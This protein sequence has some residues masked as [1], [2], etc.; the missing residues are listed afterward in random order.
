MRIGVIGSGNIGST[1]ARLFVVAGHEV[2]MANSRGPQTIGDLV[3]ELGDRAQAATA[4]DAASFGEAVLVAIPFGRYAELPAAPFAGRVVID[5][6]NY[7]PGRDGNFAELD[8]ESTT[9]S[10]LLATHVSDAMVVK[11]FNTMNWK[12]LRERGKP[13]GGSDRLALFLAGDDREAK[14][15]V[16]GL[17]DEIGFAPVDTGRLADGGRRQQPGSEIYGEPVT[18]SEARGVLAGMDR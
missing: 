6:M 10:E 8:N 17:I 7:Y 13:G 4:E 12:V 3:S 5:A 14:G 16:S 1:V 9:S 15:L 2:A 18:E 11:A